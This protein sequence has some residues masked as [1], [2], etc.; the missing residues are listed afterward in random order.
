MLPDERAQGVPGTSQFPSIN[1]YQS[2][3]IQT[4]VSTQSTLIRIHAIAHKSNTQF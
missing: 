4:P 1:R 2:F 3:F